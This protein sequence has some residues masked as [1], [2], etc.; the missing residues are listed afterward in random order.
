MA[1]TIIDTPHGI[2]Y[3]RLAALKGAIKLEKIGLRRRGRS[4]LKI[5]KE[6][7]VEGPGRVT[8]DMAIAHLEHCMKLML[9][10]VSGNG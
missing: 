5:F 2:E 4:A 10:E 1:M 9:D 8:H 7:F 6:E 3:A